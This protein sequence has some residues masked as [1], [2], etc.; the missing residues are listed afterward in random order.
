MALEQTPGVGQVIRLRF[1][2]RYTVSGLGGAGV[3]TFP[4]GAERLLLLGAA[5][6]A[7]RLRYR[8]L[9]RRPSSAP[10]EVQACR[11]LAEVY[12]CQFEEWAAWGTGEP[13]PIWGEVGV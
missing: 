10:S 3:T 6:H 11:E 9:S 5:G 8:Q 4:A 13:G 7:Y 1:R 2:K 12:R